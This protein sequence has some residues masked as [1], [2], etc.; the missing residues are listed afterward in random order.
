M[1]VMCAGMIR[2]GSTLQYNIARGIVGKAGG[3]YI[4]GNENIA[5]RTKIALADR[6]RLWV[7]KTHVYKSHL[8]GEYKHEIKIVMTY[9]DL[10]DVL[11]ST[12]AFR[13][14]SFAET[15]STLRVET[16]DRERAW[17]KHFEPHQIRRVRYEVFAFD[18]STE[19]KKM[20]AF[21]NT[22][23][24]IA[25]MADVAREN[26]R[27][28]TQKR[29]STLNNMDAHSRYGMRHIQDGSAEQWRR[30]LTDQQILLVQDEVGDWLEENGYTLWNTPQ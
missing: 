21:L 26:S 12:M 9:R 25:A 29:I 1:L 2:S 20:D 15:L 3:K 13:K 4:H 10:R 30:K 11:V 18:I 5:A 17:L 22:K 6:N 23:L 8:Y 27:V 7:N 16:V 28:E 19:V 14:R 24:S